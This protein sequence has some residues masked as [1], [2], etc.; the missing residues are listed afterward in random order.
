MPQG[1]TG[2][3]T[4]RVLTPSSSQGTESNVQKPLAKAHPGQG[5]PNGWTLPV[6]TASSHTAVLS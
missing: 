5:A 2:H 3:S 1:G 4:L 6:C